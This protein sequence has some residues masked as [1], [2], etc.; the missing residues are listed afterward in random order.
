MSINE[1]LLNIAIIIGIIYVA[2]R[3]YDSI[4]YK[5]LSFFKRNLYSFYNDPLY[6]KFV[7][8]LDELDAI[9]KR[10]AELR[11]APNKLCNQDCN[12]RQKF[13]I[14]L[15]EDNYKIL[16]HIQTTLLIQLN[17][18]LDK[19]WKKYEKFYNKAKKNYNFSDNEVKWISELAQY[20]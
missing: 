8:V 9:E 13:L 4:K 14:A 15:Y 7:S 2:I 12:S 5:I 10:K 3:I 11:D 19:L 1:I 16:S 20:G 17:N 18:S 6:N